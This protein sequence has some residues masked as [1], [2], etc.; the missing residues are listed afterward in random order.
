MFT[1]TKT[2]VN[3]FNSSKIS[4][5]SNMRNSSLEY[6]VLE[7]IYLILKLIITNLVIHIVNMYTYKL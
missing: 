6:Y 7:Y 3:S 2:V 5:S 4:I 1:N